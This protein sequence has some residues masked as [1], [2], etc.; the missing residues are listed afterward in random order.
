MS[1]LKIALYH[2]LPSG[3]AKR[4][5]FDQ[6]KRLCQNH[7]IDVYT[8]SCSEHRYADLRPYVRNYFVFPFEPLPLFRRPFGRVNQLIRLINLMRLKR[9]NQT[10]AQMINSKEYDVVYVQ[11]CQFLNS[12]PL[13]RYLIKPSVFYCH[14]TLRIVY[15][16][17]IPSRPTFRNFAQKTLD[18]LDPLPR[19]Y[20]KYL[21]NEDLLNLRSA[22]RVI[23]NSKYSQQEFLRVYQVFPSICYHGVDTSVFRPLQLERQRY[24]LSVGALRANKGFDFILQSLSLIPPEQRPTFILVTNHQDPLEWSYLSQLAQQSN[25][26]FELRVLVSDE[27]LVSLY[28]RALATLYTPINEPFGLVPLES[29]ACGTPVIGV[30]EGGVKETVLDGFNGVLS[31]RNPTTFSQKILSLVTD[32]DYIDTLGRQGHD[33]VLKN[34]SLENAILR[35]EKQLIEALNL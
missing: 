17:P 21:A 27:E 35:L 1:M 13:L 14:E 34:W 26:N 8:L 29:M 23:V 19:I 24:V 31:E 11:P 10:V 15:D 4:T 28:N 33:H 5:L 9:L 18:K 32:L 20:L 6:V 25:V 16:P 22:T 12:P 2:N 3:G 30:A 7:S